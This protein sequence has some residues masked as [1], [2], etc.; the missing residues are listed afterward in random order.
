[1]LSGVS[2]NVLRAMVWEGIAPQVPQVI[3]MEMKRQ[4]VASLTSYKITWELLKISL[5]GLHPRP[6]KP[7]AMGVGLGLRH[8]R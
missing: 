5:P 1:M 7:K 3:L 4:G 8:S 6:I 2:S